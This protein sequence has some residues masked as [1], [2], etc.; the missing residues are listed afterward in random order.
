MAQVGV[1]HAWAHLVSGAL[2]TV[3]HRQH[4]IGNYELVLQY[5][6]RALIAPRVRAT[7]E[8]LLEAFARDETL[9]VPL[10]ALEVFAA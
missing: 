10:E 8:H 6:H 1:H 2:K 4:D 7:L 9:H 3:L 5:P